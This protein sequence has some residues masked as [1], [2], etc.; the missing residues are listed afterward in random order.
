MHP[1]TRLYFITFQGHQDQQEVQEKMVNKVPPDKVVEDSSTYDG[2]EPRVLRV[3]TLSITVQ[4][5]D[6]FVSLSNYHA[7]LLSTVLFSML[8]LYLTKRP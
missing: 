7:V 4:L 1:V 5:N 2:G 3:L 8:C 6:Y